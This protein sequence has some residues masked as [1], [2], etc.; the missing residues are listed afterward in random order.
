MRQLVQGSLQGGA[1]GAIAGGGGARDDVEAGGGESEQC[2]PGPH[3]LPPAPRHTA[4]QE[5]ALRHRVGVAAARQRG[6]AE[7]DR[8]APV[9]WFRPS[10]G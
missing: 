8:C 7:R 2:A 4:W 10:R 5:P 1:G 3:S 9:G 6:E